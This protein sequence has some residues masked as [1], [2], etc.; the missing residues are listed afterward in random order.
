MNEHLAEVLGIVSSVER[1]RGPKVYRNYLMARETVERMERLLGNRSNSQFVDAAVNLALD[2]L[3][4]AGYAED[5]VD[6]L[7]MHDVSDLAQASQA[8]AYLLQEAAERLG[9]T[10][11][12]EEEE[13]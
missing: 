5:V 10:K 3:E 8:I 12:S 7:M 6:M 13:V 4:N 9:E 11:I 1:R 2:M